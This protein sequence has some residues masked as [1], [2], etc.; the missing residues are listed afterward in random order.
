VRALA[1]REQRLSQNGSFLNTLTSMRMLAASRGEVYPAGLAVVARW[2]DRA[3]FAV[4]VCRPLAGLGRRTQDGVPV[5]AR[6]VSRCE[7][8]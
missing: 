2:R 6:H 5:V 1:V 3:R 8:D 4:K 7:R